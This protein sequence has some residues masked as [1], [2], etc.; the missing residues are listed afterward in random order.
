MSLALLSGLALIRVYNAGMQALMFTPSLLCIKILA[1]FVMCFGSALMYVFFKAVCTSFLIPF[2]SILC[3]LVCGSLGLWIQI[4][5]RKPRSNLHI[6]C[7]WATIINMIALTCSNATLLN[8]REPSK[9][10]GSS[11]LL[12]LW[13]VFEGF[14][15]RAGYN[16]NTNDKMKQFQ[17]FMF[18]PESYYTTDL[19]MYMSLFQTARP[20]ILTTLLPLPI[21]FLTSF[22]VE[23]AM[24]GSAVDTRPLTAA[25]YV[26]FVMSIFLMLYLRN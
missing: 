13:A 25:F 5:F 20:L 15:A 12:M 23:T 19:N 16:L 21:A 18:S 6:T 4:K 24:R 22:M 2:F 17:R 3:I 11:A 8:L 9:V 1:I 14:A 10:L 7:T 26:V